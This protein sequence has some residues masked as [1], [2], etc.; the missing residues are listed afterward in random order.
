MYLKELKA[1]KAPPPAKDAHVGV[2]KDFNAPTAPKTP[3]LPSDLAAEL[4]KYE[5][6]EPVAA[7][8]AES[9]SSSGSLE[10]HSGGAKEFLAFLEQ[11]LPKASAHH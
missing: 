9:S 6:A 3:E 4:S 8:T 10:D 11:D 7:A 2:V 1:Y 5:S